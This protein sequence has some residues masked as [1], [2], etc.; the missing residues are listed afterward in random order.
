MAVPAARSPATRALRAA[1]LR[2]GRVRRIPFGLGRGLS[3]E[4][5]RRST[6][7]LYLGTAEIEIARHL[8]AFARPG[9]RVFDVGSNNGYYAIALSRLTG[10][11]AAAFDFADEHVQ[12]IHRNLARNP[13]ATRLVHVVQAYVCATVDPAQGADTLDHV[14]ERLFLPDLI[15]V[16]VE[17]AEVGV[18]DGARSILAERRP[19]IV[20]ETHSAELERQCAQQLTGHGYRPLVIH[21]RRLLREGRPNPHNRW[22]VAAGLQ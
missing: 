12:R 9:H 11:E 6:L 10:A 7:H 19:H 13:P 18:L 2:P 5:D 17:G 8:R 15:K 20:V 1:L 22:L 14:A 21:Q 4:V 16:D 3:L